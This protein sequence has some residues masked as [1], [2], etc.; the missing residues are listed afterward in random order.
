MIIKIALLGFRMNGYFYGSIQ[1]WQMRITCTKVK[2]GMWENHVN[3]SKSQ[4]LFF[5]ELLHLAK[6]K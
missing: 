4:Q 3:L 1:P 5:K 2:L 6:E